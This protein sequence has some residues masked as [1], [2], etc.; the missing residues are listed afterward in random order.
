MGLFSNKLTSERVYEL[1]EIKVYGMDV[2]GYPESSQICDEFKPSEKN[3]CTKD[4]C[5]FGMRVKYQG[6][7]D[8]EFRFYY[9]HKA[10]EIRAS[11]WFHNLSFYGKSNGATDEFRESIR[12]QFYI[13][14]S[15]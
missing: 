15:D 14:A 13:N 9:Y 1:L 7:W 12:K 3:L 5:Q 6:K 10:K 4:S 8:I 11:V 2:L